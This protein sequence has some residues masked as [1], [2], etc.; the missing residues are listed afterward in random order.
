MYELLKSK[1]NFGDSEIYNFEFEGKDIRTIVVEG[2]PWFVANDVALA[3]D[4]KKPRDAIKANVEEM[5]TTQV[6]VIDS[7]G[8]TQKTKAINES[9][10][11]ALMFGSK[12]EKARK[13]KHFVTSEVLPSIRKHGGYIYGQENMTD[14]EIMSR[15]LIMANSKLIALEE[16]NEQL[17][18]ENVEKTSLMEL[19]QGSKD[20]YLASEIAQCYG[21]SA[22][23]FNKLLNQFKIQKKV[24]GVWTLTKQYEENE[25]EYMISTFKNMWENKEIVGKREFNAWTKEGVL[26]IYR[27]LKEHGIV[28]IIENAV[29]VV[30]D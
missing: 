12:K 6:G 10:L 25:E 21:M 1:N 28:P 14:D 8:R 30:E 2:D 22:I 4:Y 7:L 19:L 18:M 17:K 15:A 20:R 27:T 9:G 16:K 5:D 29:T 26:F 23:K 13:F 3:L 11:Y 24:G